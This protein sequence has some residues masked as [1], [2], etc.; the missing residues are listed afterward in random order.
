MRSTLVVL[1]IFLLSIPSF[2]FPTQNSGIDAIK[3]LAERDDYMIDTTTK[4][5]PEAEDADEAIAYAW[6]TEEA[7]EAT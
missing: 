7:E 3:S 6:F 2:A 1:S 4:R 5:S